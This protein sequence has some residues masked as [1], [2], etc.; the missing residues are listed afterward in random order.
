MP[1]DI[2]FSM[3]ICDTMICFTCFMVRYTLSTDT[4]LPFVIM[5]SYD[6]WFTPLLYFTYFPDE[7]VKQSISFKIVKMPVLHL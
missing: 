5:L 2:Y 6:S 1:V 3:K 7:K 4:Y